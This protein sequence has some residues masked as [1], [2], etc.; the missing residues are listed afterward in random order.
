LP[1]AYRWRRCFET[2]FRLVRGFVAVSLASFAVIRPDF[3]FA[4]RSMIPA[5]ILPASPPLAGLPE[6]QIAGSSAARI[7]SKLPSLL[8]LF[9]ANAA[10]SRSPD[11]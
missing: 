11:H 6:C 5:N 1:L 3:S 9:G 7:S 10:M 4:A 2:T 8:T